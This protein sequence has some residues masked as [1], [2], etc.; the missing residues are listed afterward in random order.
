MFARFGRRLI[1]AVVALFALLGFAF[2]PLG[3]HTGLEHLKA[4]VQTPAA[5]RAGRELVEAGS[6]L[7]RELVEVLVAGKKPRPG[8]P[9]PRN[10]DFPHPKLGPEPANARIAPARDAAD[11]SAPYLPSI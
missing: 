1:E 4:I 11:A 3:Q 7:R 8:D 9:A 6:R 10:F 5:Q 2:V